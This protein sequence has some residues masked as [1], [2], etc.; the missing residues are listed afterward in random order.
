[1]APNQRQLV[2][3]CTAV[4]SGLTAA[5]ALLYVSDGVVAQPTRPP[6]PTP[7]AARSGAQ[8]TRAAPSAPAPT[9]CD[10]AVSNNC[11][12]LDLRLGILPMNSARDPGTAKTHL[13]TCFR[14]AGDGKTFNKQA[15]CLPASS[16][17]AVTPYSFNDQ[18][19]VSRLDYPGTGPFYAR[20]AEVTWTKR[21]VTGRYTYDYSGH[22]A[23]V[24]KLC[25]S[26]PSD[27]L[28]ISELLVGYG[29][30]ARMPAYVVPDKAAVFRT[31]HANAISKADTIG[32]AQKEVVLEAIVEKASTLCARVAK[33]YVEK[34]AGQNQSLTDAFESY[35]KQR[36]EELG[37]YKRTRDSE[38]QGLV[39]KLGDAQTRLK[40]TETKLTTAVGDLQRKDAQ[41]VKLLEQLDS[42]AP[43]DAGPD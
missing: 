22:V 5:T 33:E 37:T 6:A 18:V 27:T 40:E 7:G 29:K 41:I 3:W 35:R 12:T 28:Y 17:I 30:R 42:G 8:P 9:N 11:V 25:E 10:F 16:A 26:L 4:L 14:A 24:Y 34:L 39:D 21:T 38:V 43:V 32:S 23:Q 2:R 19:L 1:M 15:N 31:D 13:G 20:T 36:D